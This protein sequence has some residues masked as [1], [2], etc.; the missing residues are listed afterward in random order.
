MKKI[1]WLAELLNIFPFPMGLGYLYL[2]KTRNFGVTLLVAIAALVGLLWSSV[3]SRNFK[4]DVSAPFDINEAAVMR[5]AVLVLVVLPLAAGTALHAYR[6][7]GGTAK[8]F[9]PQHGRLLL[10][11]ILVSIPLALGALL[12]DPTSIW[13]RGAV[14]VHDGGSW[15]SRRVVSSLVPATALVLGIGFLIVLAGALLVT[16]KRGGL[17]CLA[18]G[19]RSLWAVAGLGAGGL[20]IL[21]GLDYAT[22]FH[23]VEHAGS[24]V[25][26]GTTTIAVLVMGFVGPMANTAIIRRL[27][28]SR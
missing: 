11:L 15:S 22:R 13:H 24:L 1:P 26:L 20:L 14:L 16:W 12:V 28:R 9:L 10:V 7:T 6:L 8:T 2:G 17:G 25:Y 18:T 27:R 23:S 3:A 4:S 21:R 19:W 5:M